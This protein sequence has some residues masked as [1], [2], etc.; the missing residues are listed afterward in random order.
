MTQE[1]R[2]ILY[3]KTAEEL[4]IN[5]VNYCYKI[6]EKRNVSW[7]IKFFL[8]SGPLLSLVAPFATLGYN[9]AII[10]LGL[11]LTSCGAGLGFGVMVA[12]ILQFRNCSLKSL[13]LTK[14][15]WK[16]LKQSGQIKEIIS[17]LYQYNRS[18]KVVLDKIVE[19]KESINKEIELNNLKQQKLQADL[20]DLE[21]KE[22]QITGK[23]PVTYTQEQVA[24]MLE[25]EQNLLLK[26]I[27][28]NKKQQ[29]LINE[30][31]DEK[32]LHEVGD[33]VKNRDYLTKALEDY[34]QFNKYLD[35]AT[36]DD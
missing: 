28:R 23:K 34:K 12:L 5:D 25:I 10:N 24:E 7:L 33:S 20:Y 9:M 22:I 16:E 36:F 18:D 8:I 21:Q 27:E 1:T 15:E 30:E 17:K 11:L 35:R 19:E 32:T 14:A 29:V 31:T 4:N 3:N 13:G 2:D 6:I 26:C